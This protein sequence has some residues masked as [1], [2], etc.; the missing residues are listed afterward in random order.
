MNNFDS[1]LGNLKTKT[2]SKIRQ[3]IMSKFWKWVSFENEQITKIEK[4]E[5]ESFIFALET[6]QN[7][8]EEKDLSLFTWFINR[9][10]GKGV[11]EKGSSMPFGR[12]TFCRIH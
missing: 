9:K 5:K 12:L 4:F 6:F 10:E 1:N 3:E 7:L 11:S 2:V 8:L